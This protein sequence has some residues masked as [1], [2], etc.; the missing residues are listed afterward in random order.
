MTSYILIQAQKKVKKRDW[1]GT[2]ILKQ[3]LK[4]GNVIVVW[5]HITEVRD[6]TDFFDYGIEREESFLTDH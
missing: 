4:M 3:I 1:N 6:L 2:M 5:I